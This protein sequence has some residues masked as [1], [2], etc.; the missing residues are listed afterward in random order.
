M[1][2]SNTTLLSS[3]LDPPNRA[4]HQAPL[5]GR[6]YLSLPIRLVG[7]TFG[8]LLSRL[9]CRIGH[10]TQELE[11]LSALRELRPN[12]PAKIPKEPRVGSGISAA[13]QHQSEWSARAVLE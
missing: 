12:P 11:V 3:I 9:N 10:V 7:Q 6:K 2:M 13:Q 8:F 4:H 5:P 1:K